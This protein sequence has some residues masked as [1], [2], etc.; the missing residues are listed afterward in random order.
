MTH[1]IYY[2]EGLYGRDHILIIENDMVMFDTAD[3]EYGVAK[4]SL[5]A[6]EAE[7]Q[8]YKQKRD[9]NLPHI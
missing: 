7:I 8:I 4:L 2:Q 1:T 3:E 9:E 6:L 5:K